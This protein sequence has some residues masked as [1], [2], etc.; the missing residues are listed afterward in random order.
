MEKGESIEWVVEDKHTIVI[1]RT[2]PP[3]EAR[4]RGNKA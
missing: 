1:R 3:S 4:R 2:P